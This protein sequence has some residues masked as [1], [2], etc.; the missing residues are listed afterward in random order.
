MSLYQAPLRRAR[1]HPHTEE[2]APRAWALF[3]PAGPIQSQP[4]FLAH[5]GDFTSTRYRGATES[6]T[7]ISLR[8]YSKRFPRV[9]FSYGGVV[10]PDFLYKRRDCSPKSGSEEREGSTQL[11]RTPI[12]SSA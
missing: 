12:K 5:F 10:P 1:V 9:L 7:S 4:S 11:S 6:Y 8:L 3:L 2:Q